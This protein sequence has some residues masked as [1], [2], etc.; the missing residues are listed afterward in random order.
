[1][2]AVNSTYSGTDF[3]PIEQYEHDEIALLFLP[4]SI[5]AGSLIFG[6]TSE[7]KEFASTN[8]YSMLF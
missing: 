3:F 5:S 8:N 6:C 2:L 1:M 7:T 4:Q